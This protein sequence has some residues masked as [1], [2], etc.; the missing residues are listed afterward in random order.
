GRV[1]VDARQATTVEEVYC[2]GEPT[3]IG[4]VDVALAEGEIAGLCAA[5][6]DGGGDAESLRG[7]LERLRRIAAAMDRTFAPRA[8]LRTLATPET[9]VCRC[10]DVPLGAIERGRPA[11]A[12]K[13]H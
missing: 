4:G 9:I 10:E 5:G 8:E 2:A 7:R 1:V 11:R 13:L 6:H 3:G 12:V